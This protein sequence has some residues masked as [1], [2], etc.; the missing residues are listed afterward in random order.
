MSLIAIILVLVSAFVH[1]G[2][3]MMVKSRQASSAFLMASV[4]VGALCLLPVLPYYS[5]YLVQVPTQVWGLLIAT[6]IVQTVY[7]MTLVTAYRNGDLSIIYPLSRAMPVLMV[8]SVTLI[9]SGIDALSQ[10]TIA[11][12]LLIVAGTFLI[13]LTR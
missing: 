12:M 1:A 5:S 11:G 10:T 2:W 4:T 8:G 9:G 6:G 3:N 13:P 7:N